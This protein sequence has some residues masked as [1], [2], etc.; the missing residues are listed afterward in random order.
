MEPI[1]PAIRTQPFCQMGLSVGI[2]L[3]AI[4]LEV[5][6]RSC[7]EPLFGRSEK[8]THDP[9]ADAMAGIVKRVTPIQHGQ[10]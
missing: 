6:T 1:V 2:D 7:T 8:A 5:H 3:G 9:V 10:F 4:T